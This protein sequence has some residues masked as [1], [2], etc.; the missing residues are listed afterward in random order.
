MAVALGVLV[1]VMMHTGRRLRRGEGAILIA[2]YV[3]LV[4]FLAV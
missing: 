3:A 2:A 4:P 1:W